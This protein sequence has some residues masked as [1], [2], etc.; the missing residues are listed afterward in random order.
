MKTE[1][2]QRQ[3]EF[4]GIG[5]RKVVGEFAGGTITSDAGALLLRE[6]DRT[7]SLLK[8]F[9]ECFADHRN[10]KLIEHPVEQLVAQ[11]VI[12]LCLS[13]ED[14]NDHEFLRKDPLLAA[15]CGQG[16]VEGRRR[17][18]RRD[19]G[20]ALAGKSTLNR[21]EL[22][23]SDG[24]APHRYRKIVVHPYSIDELLIDV[25]LEQY[26]QAPEEIVL[27]VDATDDPLHG[28]Q[29]G[30]FFNGYYD[31]WCYLPLYIF[32]GQHLLHARLRR[33]DCDPLQGVLPALAMIYG[34]VAGRWPDTRIVVRGDSAFCREEVM[35]FCERRKLHYVLGL[36]KNSIVTEMLA[37]TMAMSKEQY[38]H[39]AGPT[40][41][42]YA[43]LNYRTTSRS[44][45][46]T[47][48]VVG[49][50][51]FSAAGENPRF[52][53]TSFSGEECDAQTLYEQKY[54]ARGD[55][56]NRIK[57]QQLYL[58]ADRTSTGLFKANQLRLWFSSIAYVL[59]HLLRSIGCAGT[60]FAGAQCH[61]LRL[62]LL[63]IGALVKLSVRRVTVHMASGYPYQD[64]F[65]RIYANLQRAAP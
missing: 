5:G 43:D 25:F 1:C 26:R 28:N 11:R 15:V 39:D 46:R 36:A 2:S 6:A 40:I 64:Q 55:M 45:S 3:L 14:L 22:A 29:E 18:R 54:C 65:R 31:R 4:Q 8:R 34:K 16:D 57:E 32:C 12:G 44:W 53:V 23:A 30:R 19:R 51:E 21:L 13:Y 17:R 63:K 56:E 27:D 24:G 42:R 47:R 52:V 60:E 35:S 37:P 20:A 59:M 48:R 62:R 33:S 41:R 61:S 49:K 9:A 58:F 7:H 50:A 10:P 38:L